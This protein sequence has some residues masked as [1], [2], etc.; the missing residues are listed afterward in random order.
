MNTTN[1]KPTHNEEAERHGISLI[2]S[3]AHEAQT[4]INSMA[5]LSRQMAVTNDIE[6][7]KQLIVSIEKDYKIA[8][9]MLKDIQSI[10]N[11]PDGENESCCEEQA[12]ATCAESIDVAIKAEKAATDEA[13]D[14]EEQQKKII[15]VAEDNNSNFILD[16]MILRKDYEV[17]HAWNGAEAVEM[18]QKTRP[19][20]V[21]MDIKMPVMN[22]YEAFDKIK[23]IDPTI[24]II[25]ITAYSLAEEENKIIEKG[26][27]AYLFK[28]LSAEE[29]SR[30]I[31]SKVKE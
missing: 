25:A 4:P 2:A 13:Q 21:L 23:A 7:R 10:A 5:E 24:P 15:L 8:Q 26:F 3:I 22:G 19:D 31:N 9:K 29:F 16:L 14:K 17:I 20:L 27:D 30:T 28:P 11:N 1:T 12:V 6:E 18:V